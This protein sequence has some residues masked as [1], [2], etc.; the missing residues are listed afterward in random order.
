MILIINGHPSRNSFTAAIA[1]SYCAGAREAAAQVEIL[2]LGE[3]TFDPI[4]H[5]GYGKIM[6]LEPDLVRAQKL[7]KESQR[8]VIFYPQWWGSGPALLKGFIDRTFLPGFAFHYRDKSAL[9]DKLLVGRS[10]ELW[11]LSDS[12]RFWFFIMYWN[13]PIKWL[14]SATLEFCGFKPVKVNIVDRV[15]FLSEEQRKKILLKAR[16]AGALA[17]K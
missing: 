12:P 14:K 9:W 11:L 1:D 13:S 2:H 4:L 7:I 15:R 6:P 17:S 5:D 10:A 3:L 16:K 8:L